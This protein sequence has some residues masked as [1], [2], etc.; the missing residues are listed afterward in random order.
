[1]TNSISSGPL[2]ASLALVPVGVAIADPSGTFQYANQ[3][4]CEIV[5]CSAEE[6]IGR[7]FLE[8]TH[9]DDRDA[10]LEQV[11][12]L[13]RGEI[14]SFVMEKRYVRRDGNAVWVKI[15]ASVEQDE[16][17]RPERIIGI[18]ENIQAQKDAEETRAAADRRAQWILEGLSEAVVILD[19][20]FRI[21]YANPE[22]CRINRKSACTFV[23]KSQWE[24]WP[25]T[26]GTEIEAAYRRAMRER[27][28]E[29][30]EYF[31]AEPFNIWLHVN[32]CP[33]DEG[34][35]VY[36][37]D[38]TKSRMAQE[39]LRRANEEL[40]T[41]AY[42]AGHDLQEPL[43]T[44]TA[45]TQLLAN[46]YKSHLDEEGQEFVEYIVGGTKR[47]HQLIR[48]LLIYSRLAYAQES[49][50][51]TF[52]PV[53]LR[54]L[55]ETAE[56]SLRTAI[57]ESGAQIECGTLPAVRGDETQL[58]Q[59]FQNLLSNAI[60]YGRHEA[61]PPEIRIDA[62]QKENHWFISVTDN[63]PG[64]APENRERIFGLFKRL[65][66]ADI[67]GTGVGLALCRKII[68]RH[69]GRIWA[70]ARPDGERGTR[71]VFTL[72]PLAPNQDLRATSTREG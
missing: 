42:A 55:V 31:H 60:K 11:Q 52:A 18:A 12:E 5:D 49:P 34:L 70:D 26:V 32:L 41:F 53:E 4:Y 54:E 37:R 65:H 16:A 69:G 35:A 33:V 47:M 46:R 25:E 64:I 29:S 50:D 22:A 48:D 10:N 30:L 51:E 20:D 45:Y 57:L 40:Q 58:A 13:L 23:G 68:E 61:A 7:H 6:L 59:I 3:A 62:E 24:E 9:P 36:Y 19:W 15:S 43:R 27:T 21:T 56:A 44:I 67:P 38:I 63:G 66:R 17:G 72:P 2:E 71:I 14:P 28:T 39:A 1:M 8:F